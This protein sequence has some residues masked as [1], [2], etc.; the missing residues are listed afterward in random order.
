MKKKLFSLVMAVAMIAALAV[1]SFASSVVSGT[2]SQEGKVPLTGA[3]ALPTVKVT[4]PTSG[5][6]ILNPYKMAVAD[7]GNSTEVAASNSIDDQV[8][9]A[10]HE[11]KNETQAPMKVGISIKATP[12]TGVELATK[13]CTGKETTKSVF[14]FAE[15]LY[16]G[17]EQKT[18]QNLKDLWAAPADVNDKCYP[19]IIAST[20]EKGNANFFT[21]PPAASASA[22]NYL[23]WTI[24]GNAATAPEEKWTAADTVGADVVFTFT[25]DVLT[26]IS[27]TSDNTA[28]VAQLQTGKDLDGEALTDALKGDFAIRAAMG[29]VVRIVPEPA[30]DP[31]SDTSKAGVISAVEVKDSTGAKVTATKVNANL[32]YFVAT[33]PSNPV[34][35]K[36]TGTA[37]T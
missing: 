14:M 8:L 18:A 26:E 11:I 15:L 16:A 9:S 22:P 3:T 19:Q 29:T 35:V 32:Y 28:D 34:T 20:E 25:P 24:R 5:K 36:I 27:Y 7:A 2:G 17:T 13:A 6:V 12:S 31:T 23:Y 1:P 21:V 33:A 10:S 4:I 37:R 30:T